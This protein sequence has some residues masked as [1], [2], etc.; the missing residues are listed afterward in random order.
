MYI[1]VSQLVMMLLRY[2]LKLNDVTSM[3]GTFNFAAKI[4]IIANTNK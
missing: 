3:Y 1:A 4:D 2:L